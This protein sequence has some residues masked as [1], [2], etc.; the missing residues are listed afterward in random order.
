MKPTA[1]FINTARAYMVDY[2]Y[3]AKILKEN[4]IMGAALEVFPVE[5]LPQDSPF[6]SLDNVSLT[7]HRGGDTVNCYSDSPEYL[8][9]QLYHLLTEGKRP[10]FFID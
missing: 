4:R 10:K 2:D 9:T 6:I 5:P 1:V 8:L 3:L 7:N